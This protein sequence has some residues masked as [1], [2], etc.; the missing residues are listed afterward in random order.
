MLSFL[1]LLP[2]VTIESSAFRT[3]TW[4]PSS[5]WGPEKQFA[6]VAVK[7]SSKR[8]G[9][10]CLW[11]GSTMKNMDK[12]NTVLAGG[13]FARMKNLYHKWHSRCHLQSADNW[14]VHKLPI[15]LCCQVPNKRFWAFCSDKPIRKEERRFRPARKMDSAPAKLSI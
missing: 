5:V 10:S 12:W 15:F 3:W 9:R 2:E 13:L 11:L 8:G 14:C 6:T 1:K 7:W 4:I